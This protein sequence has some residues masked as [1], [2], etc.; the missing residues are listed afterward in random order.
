[1]INLLDVESGKVVDS[2]GESEDVENKAAEDVV[3]S[4]ALSED[5]QHV[6]SSHK[7]GLFRLWHLPGEYFIDVIAI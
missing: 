6:V 4:F 7:S 2:L 1:L 3:I 5:G